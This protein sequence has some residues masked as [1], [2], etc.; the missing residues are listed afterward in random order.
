MGLPSLS[1]YELW[2]TDEAEFCACAEMVHSANGA[3]LLVFDFGVDF[4]KILFVKVGKLQSVAVHFRKAYV[5][6]ILLFL[7]D[8][9][10]FASRTFYVSYHIEI[11]Q[12]SGYVFAV[13]LY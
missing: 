3:K 4:F 10:E 11:S 13:S 8:I 7:V 6:I 5:A 9:I 2:R 1:E 12:L